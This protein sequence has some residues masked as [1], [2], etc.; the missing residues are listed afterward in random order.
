MAA[1]T[2]KTED[3]F[4]IDLKTEPSEVVSLN[5]LKISVFGYYK[6]Q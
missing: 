4:F 5:L 3:E 6:C 2:I 1:V